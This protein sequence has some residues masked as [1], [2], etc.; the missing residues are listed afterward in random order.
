MTFYDY[1]NARI[2]ERAITLSWNNYHTYTIQFDCN[3]LTL[4]YISATLSIPHIRW[5]LRLGSCLWRYRKKKNIFHLHSII[6]P[7]LL[8]RP[9]YCRIRSYHRWNSSTIRILRNHCP[10]YFYLWWCLCHPPRLSSRFIRFE[11]CGCYSRQ[12]VALL[13]HSSPSW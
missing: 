1:E 6:S 5:S 2:C 10:C 11:E 4:L 7:P 13:I 12:N 9:Y 8:C 3:D